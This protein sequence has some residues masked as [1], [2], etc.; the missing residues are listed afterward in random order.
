[1]S[2]PTVLK[3]SRATLGALLAAHI[4]VCCIS[5]V[6]LAK[7]R[8]AIEFDP[9]T[10]H[11]FFR[12]DQLPIALVGVA[13][14]SLVAGLFLFTRFSIGYF[15][16]FYLYTMTLS[17]IWLNSFSDLNYNHLLAGVSAALSC[18]IFLLPVLFF[19]SPLAPALR[20]SPDTFDRLLL[21]ILGLAATTVLAG[22]YYNFS[23]ASLAELSTFREN[24]NT[25][26]ILKYA[27]G[28]TS[29][30]L[31]PFAFAAFLAR[32]S[33]VYGA[34]CIFLQLCLFPVTL[35]KLALFAPLWLIY[36]YILSKSVSARIAVV[37]SLLL[38]LC[39]GLALS[40]LPGPASATTFSLINFRMV[41]IP[42]L[43][44]D[45]Y[46]DF[47]SR[48]ELTHFCQISL[49][50]LVFGCQYPDLSTIMNRTYALGYFNASL[51]ATEGVASVGPFF[52][53]LAALACGL[54]V[55]IGNKASADL[56]PTFVMV[57][58]GML[59]QVLLNVP[60]SVAVVTHGMAL[61]WLLWYITPR[62]VFRAPD[63]TRY[64]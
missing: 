14:F 51:F 44:M 54:L 26:R 7:G 62:T 47:F 18:A 21:V 23:F 43:A 45:V 46:S 35:T 42:A 49:V 39:L 63:P 40:Q 4:L 15:I 52:A 30:T 6:V 19:T 11:F 41:A 64:K 10:F 17:Y 20:I 55:A 9:S 61:L 60:L 32:K 8:A 48:H 5:L 33:Y 58:G 38:P 53:P 28:V 12:A 24:I 59:P 3:S 37:L 36:L 34:I 25:P 31:L 29:T 2:V 50:K 56:P 57:S 1:M 13:G 27:L 22:A 16:G